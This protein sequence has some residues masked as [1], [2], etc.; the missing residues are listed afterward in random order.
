MDFL[1]DIEN[2]KAL[3]PDAL[4]VKSKIEKHQKSDLSGRII[5]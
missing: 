1:D 4:M 3:S 2:R 5:H